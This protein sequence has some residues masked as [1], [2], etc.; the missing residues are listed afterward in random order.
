[1]SRRVV[2]R[3]AIVQR[4]FEQRGH[5]LVLGFDEKCPSMKTCL[6]VFAVVQPSNVDQ[7]L[8]CLLVSVGWLVGLLAGWMADWLA[9]WALSPC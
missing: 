1:M 5:V 8:T 4:A 2:D 7:V 3:C 6:Y 9:G